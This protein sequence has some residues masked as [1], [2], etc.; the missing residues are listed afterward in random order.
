MRLLFPPSEG[1]TDP[2]RGTPLEL[3]GLSFPELEPP[4][5]LVLDAL[6][7]LCTTDPG[8][9]C[10]TLG[11]TPNQTAEVVRNQNL[12]SAPTAPAWQIYSGVLYGQLDAA[13]LTA[14]QRTRLAGR[15][16][17]AS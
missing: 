6:T 14:A 16:W 15:V 13:S 9:A 2:R 5:R 10:A 3:T 12:W 17:I 11:L 4:R 7:T 8:G 1:K